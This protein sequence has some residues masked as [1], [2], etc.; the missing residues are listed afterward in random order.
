MSLLSAFSR[1]Y[2][3]PGTRYSWTGYAPS[4]G[5]ANRAY[6]RVSQLRSNPDWRP[7]NPA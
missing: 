1:D 6:L 4:W 7:K 3:R 5:Q 2:G